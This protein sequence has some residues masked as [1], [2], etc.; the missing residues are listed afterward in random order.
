M[1]A[2]QEAAGERE[3]TAGR[4]QAAWEAPALA[5]LAD[6]TSFTQRSHSQ[7]LRVGRRKNDAESHS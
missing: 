7:L 6:R 1:E 4:I 3:Q 2:E 5:Q